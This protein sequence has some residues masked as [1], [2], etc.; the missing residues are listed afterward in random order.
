M[1]TLLMLLALFAANSAVSAVT[2]F[3]VETT[4]GV[5]VYGDLYTIDSAN[6]DVRDEPS[7]TELSVPLILLFHQGGGDA[8]G[9]YTPLVSRL[10][11]AGY[12]LLSIDQ[13][14]GGDRFGGVNRT[15]ARL[16][17]RE[18]S[19][20]DAYPDLEAALRFA[21]NYGFTGKIIAWGSSYSAALVIKLASEHPD[22]IDAVLAFSP[23]SGEPMAGC[24]PDP[25]SANLEQPLLV[26]R[27]EREAAIP[28][29]VEQMKRF[30]EQGH[31]THVATPGL[32]GSSMLDAE[33]VGESTDETWSVVLEFLGEAVAR[34]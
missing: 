30:A 21:I 9:E 5:I 6:A 25:Y 26:L 18:Y 2:E 11:G 12:N 32:H 28:S 14:S 33:R 23:A 4:D 27:P 15:V 31:R 19:Y 10:T 16:G 29:V 24:R 17:D 8:R 7:Y 20:C 22:K 1:K 34:K 13:R 3:S